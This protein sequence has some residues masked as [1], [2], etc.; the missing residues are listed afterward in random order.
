MTTSVST[1]PDV[2]RL[3][4]HSPGTSRVEA[5]GQPS[6]TGNSWLWQTTP[7]SCGAADRPRSPPLSNPQDHPGPSDLQQTHSSEEAV[8][9]CILGEHSIARLRIVMAPAVYNRPIVQ[10][11]LFKSACLVSTL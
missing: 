6:G 10:T 5:A 3:G 4:V 7:G 2:A 8:Q 9:A 1:T 11:K